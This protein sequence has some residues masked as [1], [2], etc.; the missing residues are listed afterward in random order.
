MFKTSNTSL[1]FHL[2]KSSEDETFEEFLGAESYEECIT[3]TFDDYL[4]SSFCESNQYQQMTVYIDVP[5]AL[6]ERKARA[7][8]IGSKENTPDLTG[9]GLASSSSIVGEKISEYE[10]EKQRN[11]QRNADL[12]RKL[13]E[14]YVKKH[15]EIPSPLA[16]SSAKK[17]RKRKGKLTLDTERR[18]STRL[19]R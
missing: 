10:L 8:N 15:G 17:P 2:G 18:A 16:S 14:D 4:N 9:Q 12:L 1:R 19:S 6:A 7:L 3:S 13:D 11:I 5:V